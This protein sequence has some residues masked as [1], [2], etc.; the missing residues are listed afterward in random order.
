MSKEHHAAYL[1]ALE[2]AGEAPVRGKKRTTK[3]TEPEDPSTRFRCA[4]GHVTGR[5]G[6]K[7]ASTAMEEHLDREHAGS[8]RYEL[9]L[10]G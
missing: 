8:G 1:R 7:N 6:R 10:D 5:S 3:V 9:V 2:V 4:C